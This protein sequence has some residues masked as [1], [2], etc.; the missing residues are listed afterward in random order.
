MMEVKKE[1]NIAIPSNFRL[2]VF[3]PEMLAFV[4]AIHDYFRVSPMRHTI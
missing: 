3:S 4:Q 1:R 2:L